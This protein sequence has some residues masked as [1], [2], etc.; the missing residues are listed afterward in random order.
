MGRPG[1]GA[2]DALQQPSVGT[3]NTA[4]RRHRST[5]GLQVVFKNH[6]GHRSQRKSGWWSDN[7]GTSDKGWWLDKGNAELTR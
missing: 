6:L 1:L 3:G 7:V 2:A 5:Q 4:E